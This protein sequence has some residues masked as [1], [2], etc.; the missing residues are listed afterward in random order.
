VIGVNGISRGIGC[1]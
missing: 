1:V